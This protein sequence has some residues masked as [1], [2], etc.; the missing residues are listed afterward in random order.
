MAEKREVKITAV[1]RVSTAALV[2]E[3]ARAGYAGIYLVSNEDMRSQ[4][5]IK[6]A[7][8]LLNRKL[9]TWTLGRGL[10]EDGV[11]SRAPMG[12]TEDPAGMLDTLTKVNDRDKPVLPEECIV[13]LRLGHHI[14]DDPLIQSK[15][16]DIIPIF[17]MTK[18]MLVVLAPVIKLPL[19]I[20]KEFAMIETQLPGKTQLLEVL[21]GII[22]GS[23]LPEALRPSPERR[24]ELVEAALGL[25]TNEAENAMSL[26]IVK[27]RIAIRAAIK[28]E[29]PRVSAE[30]ADRLA[31][32]RSTMDVI[33]DPK[34]VMEEKCAALK[35]TGLLEYIPVRPEGL[36]QVGGLRNLKEW[37]R[38]RK[39]AFTQRARDFGLPPPKGMLCVGPAGA[40]KSLCAKAISGEL[41]MPLLRLDMGKMFGSLVGQSEANIRMAIQVAEALSPCILWIDEVEKG[42]AGS[43]A[44]ALDSGVGARVLGTILTWM[45]EKTSSV[46]VYATANDVTALPPEFLRKGRFDEMFSVNLPNERERKEILDIHIKKRGR[47]ALLTSG[48]IDTAFFAKE[49]LEGFSGAEIEAGIVEAMYAAFD[50]GKDLN[51]FDLQEAFDATMPLSKTMKEKLAKLSEWCKDRT[52]PANTVDDP[53]R[54]A[55]AGGRN[56]DA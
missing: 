22:E 3:K 31:L 23:N 8:K 10:V 51:S 26:S 25:T 39:N 53:R 12:N 15:L 30:E 1:E 5:E 54:H 16:L 2:F 32:S 4:R 19:E 52:R 45:Q 14:L 34:V 49:T 38:K 24:E 43:S 55:Q 29:Y 11:K 6:E 20:E 13:V 17:K 21:D 33:W 28:H 41:L 36:N 44:G 48:K 47:E 7:A 50:A 42:L 56:L 27:P 40:G 37:V 9:F 46:F 35:K 18:R